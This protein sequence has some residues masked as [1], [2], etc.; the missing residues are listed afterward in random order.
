MGGFSIAAV[1]IVNFILFAVAKD[2][3]GGDAIGRTTCN[4]YEG[5]WM[6]DPT[7]PLYDPAKCPF[8]ESREFDCQRN[9]RPDKYYL[10]FRWQPSACNLPRF[11]GR[12]FLM[13]FRGKQIMFVGDS[14]SLNQWQSLT[15][16]IHSSVPQASYVSKK[17]GGLS[18]FTFPEYKMS[19]LFSRNAFLVDIK[20]ESIGRVL[21]LDSVEGSRELWEGVD[22][23]IFNSWHWW[24]HVGRQ[25]PWDVIQQGNV[26]Y[27]DMNR[28]MAYQKA[29]YTW[30]R[31]VNSRVNTKKTKVIFQG[32]SPDHA[33]GAKGINC[34]GAKVPLHEL[35]PQGTVHPAEVVLQ[36]VLSGMRKEVYL[37]D[38]TGLS[39]LRIDGHPS[40]Y[41]I[42]GYK[43]PD[44]SHWCLPGLPDTWNQLL[45]TA[46]LP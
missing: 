37:L 32:V 29:L 10:H 22:V 38:I 40:A 12:E 44:C 2:A 36:R 33:S 15:C 7:Y 31:W 34:L 30:A 28:L 6:Y 18:N 43:I 19:L 4:I 42:G 21:D 1:A 16:M 35:S 46:L 3:Q 5:K 9:G 39:Q 45:Y 20:S 23:L 25:Q 14:L 17:I 24:L 27:P 41:G 13:R 11:S 8:L 26:T